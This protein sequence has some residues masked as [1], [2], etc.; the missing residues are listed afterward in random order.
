MIPCQI[1][2]IKHAPLKTCK[3]RTRESQTWYDKNVQTSKWKMRIS[4]RKWRKS[5]HVDDYML[6]SAKRSNYMKIL[7]NKT[8]VDNFNSTIKEYENDQR[9]LFKVVKGVCRSCKESPLPEHDSKE[10][11]A[12]NVGQFFVEKIEN[13]QIDKIRDNLR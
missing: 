11:L 10:E 3:L 13:R 1:S 2:W 4:E 7:R 9:P 8:K 12:E 6:F 5:R